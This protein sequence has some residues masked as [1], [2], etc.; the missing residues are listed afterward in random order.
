[1]DA[2]ATGAWNERDPTRGTRLNSTDPEPLAARPRL[3]LERLTEL[4]VWL[5]THPY[6]RERGDTAEEVRLARWVRRQRATR[7]DLSRWQQQRLRALPGWTWDPLRDRFDAGYFAARE[8]VD[9]RGHLPRRVSDDPEERAAGRFLYRAR[10]RRADLDADRTQKL[11]DVE[12]A[13]RFGP[14]SYPA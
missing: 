7:R 5:Q 4:E 2:P 10:R 3:W 13:A 1:M 9:R 11:H 6:P 12:Q 8:F 14:H